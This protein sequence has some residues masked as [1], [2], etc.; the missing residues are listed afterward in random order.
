MFHAD[1]KFN[2]HKRRQ[3]IFFEN[4]WKLLEICLKLKSFEMF[5]EIKFV[6]FFASKN[7]NLPSMHSYRQ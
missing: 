7:S 4:P 6:V 5:L 1:T 2:R 3:E